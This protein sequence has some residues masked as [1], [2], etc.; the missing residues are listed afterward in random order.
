[1][2]TS[3]R[4]SCPKSIKIPPDLSDEWNKLTQVFVARRPPQECVELHD[5]YY[6][7]LGKIQAMFNR[8]HD[9]VAQANSGQS[10][11]ALNALTGMMGTASSEADE[12]A[13]SADDALDEICRQYK[14]EKT[15]KIQTDS[16]SSGSLLH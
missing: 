7:H 11:D 14:L 6:N 10:G 12:T 3:R 1:M 5:K 16:G 13:Q 8:V 4:S 2:M 9:A 15:F